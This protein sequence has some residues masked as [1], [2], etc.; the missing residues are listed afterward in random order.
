MLQKLITYFC[1]LSTKYHTVLA[2]KA[3]GIILTTLHESKKKL[4]LAPSPKLIFLTAA[5]QS[6]GFELLSFP[7]LGSVRHRKASEENVKT[8]N[9]ERNKVRLTIPSSRQSKTV[10]T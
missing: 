6:E 2:N 5:S 9:H 8:G 10:L 4:F 1:Q 3:L 7:I